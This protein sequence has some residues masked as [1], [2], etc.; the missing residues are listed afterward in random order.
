VN[1]EDFK[2][3]RAQCKVIAL[4]RAKQH[5]IIAMEGGWGVGKTR[6]IPYLMMC[7]HEDNPGQNGFYV[8][9][10]M[11][12]GARTISNEVSFLLEPIGWRFQSFYKG[13]PAPH[14]VS[15]PHPSNGA[16]TRVW[17]LSW[18]RP[19]TKATSAN[20][21]EGPD[22]GWGIADECNQYN[23]SEMATAMLGRVRSGS[24]GRIVLLG[25]PAPNCWWRAIADERNELPGGAFKAA[26]ICNKENLP[27]YDTWVKTLSPREVAENL[28]CQPIAPADAVLDTFEPTVW[29]SGNLTE[30]SWEPKRGMKTHLCMDFGARMPAALVLSYDRDACDGDGAWVIWLEAVPDEASV[31]DVCAILKA[32]RPDLGIPGIW[33]AWRNDAPPGSIP[34][35]HAFGDRAG[36]ARRDDAQLSSASDDFISWPDG[37][38][39]K[40]NVTD[41]RERI[42]VINGIK[43]LWRLILNNSG[44][45]TLLVSHRLWFGGQ[46]D[47]RRTISSCVMNYKWAS[48]AKVVPQ[49]GVWDHSID[50][51]RYWAINTQWPNQAA[52]Q[53]ARAAFKEKTKSQ[54]IRSRFS[55]GDDR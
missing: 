33:P 42:D 27:F 43:L 40:L 18:K 2:P 5:P 14:W 29:P 47:T 38:G 30:P 49:K 1:E 51:L 11:S 31:Y 17:A 52:P 4:F 13:T 45:R 24:P 7:A 12:R 41:D 32:G 28:Y 16:V 54:R 20:S 50:A 22:C 36:R 23:D 44:K 55:P 9:D 19:S 6:M 3:N 10:S 21:L 53:I 34:C 46:N 39:L 15:P 26:T 48:G 37:I 25:K 35:T 8:T